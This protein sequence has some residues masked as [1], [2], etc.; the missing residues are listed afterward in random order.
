M[1][2]TGADN[3]R[4]F[5]ANNATLLSGNFVDRGSNYERTSAE[6]S[7]GIG[8]KQLFNENPARSLRRVA[9]AHREQV[10]RGSAS[11]S[12]KERQNQSIR[13]DYSRFEGL[14]DIGDLPNRETMNGPRPDINYDGCGICIVDVESFT[15]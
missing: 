9:E 7:H 13:E 12:K 10:T 3:T 11:R 1:Q 2:I 5:Q 8:S 15:G 6:R 4:V 14:P